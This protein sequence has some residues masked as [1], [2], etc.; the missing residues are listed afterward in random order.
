MSS[1]LE[2]H[3]GHS[4]V[5][6]CLQRR[7]SNR[8]TLRPPKGSKIAGRGRGLILKQQQF[9]SRQRRRCVHTSKELIEKLTPA[10]RR[11]HTGGAESEVRNV[12]GWDTGVLVQGDHNEK[13]ALLQLSREMQSRQKSAHL[14]GAKH[15]K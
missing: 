5:Q 1:S 15:M 11:R 8:E 14:V 6:N 10:R 3:L 9:I 4:S 13:S 2:E 12:L 7:A